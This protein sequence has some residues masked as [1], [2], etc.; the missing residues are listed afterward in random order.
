MKVETYQL[1]AAV[2]TATLFHQL[3]SGRLS[4]TA[5]LR[6]EG[7]GQRLTIPY[8][9]G[10][11]T[12]LFELRQSENSLDLHSPFGELKAATESLLEPDPLWQSVGEICS[13]MQEDHRDTFPVFLRDSEVAAEEVSMPWVEQ[14]GFF[15]THQDRHHWIP[16]PQLC[17][18]PSL[19]RVQ[20]IKMLKE[21]RSGQSDR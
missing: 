19:V 13:H 9:E 21:L 12:T 2:V 6:R 20:L 4:P 11:A 10:G 17:P 5:H 14:A 8:H 18:E 7:S 1:N 15:L 3:Q 16:F